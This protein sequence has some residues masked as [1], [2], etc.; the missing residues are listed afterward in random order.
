MAAELRPRSR[1]VTLSS[2]GNR[3]AE[4]VTGSGQA[5]VSVRMLRGRLGLLSSGGYNVL[6]RQLSYAI[7]NQLEVPKAPIQAFPV[8]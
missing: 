2:E 7:K 4:P 6:L 8:S 3:G 1:V 5:I